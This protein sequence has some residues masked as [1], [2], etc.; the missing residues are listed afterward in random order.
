MPL[1]ISVRVR[2]KL[3]TQ[4]HAVTEDEILECFANRDGAS[5]LDD[6]EEHRTNPPTRWFVAQTDR[7]RR[8]K[9][10][11]VFDPVT[12]IIEIK[13]AYVATDEVNR[14]YLKYAR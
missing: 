10:C 7:G 2:E 11:Y 14:I 9:I 8:L 3:Q 13:T 12:N 5:C 1:L 4:S 6:R